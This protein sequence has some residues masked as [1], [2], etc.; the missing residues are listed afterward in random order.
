MKHIRTKDGSATL[1]GAPAGQPDLPLKL[2]QETTDADLSAGV[3][4]YCIREMYGGEGCKVPAGL[5][6]R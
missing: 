4:R 5:E 6:V 3:C 1:C 2:A